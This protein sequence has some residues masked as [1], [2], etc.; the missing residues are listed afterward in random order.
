MHIGV[1]HPIGPEGQQCVDGVS[2][3]LEVLS[4]AHVRELPVAHAALEWSDSPTLSDFVSDHGTSALFL[5][6][7]LDEHLLEIVEVSRRHHVLTGS[8]S[9]AYAKSGTSVAIVATE[10]KYRIVVNLKASRA[11]GVA[12]SASFLN[13]TEV[14]R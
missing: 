9:E 7:G 13:L 5:C 12:F 6:P 4:G 2:A 1:V 10:G 8:W 14:I 11:E 3:A